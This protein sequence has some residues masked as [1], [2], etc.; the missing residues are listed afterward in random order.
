MS[1]YVF[2]SLEMLNYYNPENNFTNREYVKEMANDLVSTLEAYKLKGTVTDIRMTPFAVLFDIIPDPGVTVKSIQSLRL[3]LEVHMASPI[4][5]VSVGEGK[6]TI[7]LAVKNWNRPLIGL[8]DIMETP[9]FKN[10]DYVI[11]VAAGMN[12]LGKPFV[13]DLAATP[14]LLIAGTTGSGKSTFLNTIVLSV[15]YTRTPEQVR[16]WMVDSKGVDLRAFNRIPHMLFPVVKKSEDALGILLQAEDV[17]KMRYQLFAEQGVKNID[18]YNAVV[19][20]EKAIPR[21]VI[22]IDEYMEMMTSGE[23]ELE[24]VIDSLSRQARAAGIHLVLATQRP[25][26]KVITASIKAN[27][28]CRAAFTVVDWRE[29]K[30]IVD[31]TGAE[32]LLGNGD[33]L[34]S[35]GDTAVPIH[36]QAAYVSYKEVDQAIEDVYKKN[37]K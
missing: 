24:I 6:Y 11:P 27:I 17:M 19:P 8:R 3:E 30:T 35:L 15:M 23:K 9:E 12:V 18:G 32:R 26:S 14:H 22:I 21:I 16:F 1:E 25:T 33:M 5:I 34:F 28:P 10:N 13:F 31:R 20:S 7:G 37:K 36:A 4:E 2:P 29:S